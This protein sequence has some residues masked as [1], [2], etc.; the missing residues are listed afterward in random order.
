MHQP[1]VVPHQS[2]YFPYQVYPAFVQS[3]GIATRSPVLIVGAGPIGLTLALEL[4][5]YGVG[6]V[7]LAAQQQVCEGSRA[8][9]LHR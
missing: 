6:S 4:A 7:V 8:I 3:P 1:Q 2:L 5:R 9:V